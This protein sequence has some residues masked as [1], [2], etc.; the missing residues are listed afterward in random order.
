VEFWFPDVS[1]FIFSGQGLEARAEAARSRINRVLSDLPDDAFASLDPDAFAEELAAPERM[2]TPALDV[3]AAKLE[4]EGRVDAIDCTNVPGLSMNASEAFGQ[5][6]IYRPG[7]RFRYFIPGVGELRLLETSVVGVEPLPGSIDSGRG[8]GFVLCWPDALGADAMSEKVRQYS[9][10]IQRGVSL[11]A[12]RVE[13]ENLAMQPFARDII[14]RRVDEIARERDFLGG[15]TIPVL[16]V[17]EQPTEFDAPPIAKIETP[18]AESLTAEAIEALPPEQ[19]EPTLDE[20]YPHILSIIRAVGRGLERSVGSFRDAGEETLRD[21]MLV[22]LNTHYRGATYAEAFNKEGKADLL[23]R[24]FDRNAFIGECKW[25][26]GPSGFDE[27]LD[28]LLGYAAWPDRRLALIIYVK[29]KDFTGTIRTASEQIEGRKDFAR[30]LDPDDQL[31]LRCQLQDND[32]EARTPT[33][34]VVFVHLI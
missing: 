4:P 16:Q 32:D 13:E 33:L 22:T 24:V 23:I 26:S 19:L 10:A 5:A 31:E 3:D 12:Q 18:V 14:Q 11:L 25:W 21:H 34:A 1:G 8:V 20:F 2:Q 6:R 29:N 15:L 9:G 7:Y 27:A 17:D 28:Q 30:W